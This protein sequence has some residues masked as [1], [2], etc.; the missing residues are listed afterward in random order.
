MWTFVY[1]Y[2]RTQENDWCVSR[3]RFSTKE[4]AAQKAMEWMVICEENDYPIAIHLRRLPE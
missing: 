1:R 2:L 4:E 3:M